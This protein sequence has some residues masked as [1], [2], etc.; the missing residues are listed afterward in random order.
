M[1]L[2][3]IDISTRNWRDIRSQLNNY[4]YYIIK[5][6]NHAKEITMY[7]SKIRPAGH[8]INK[9]DMFDENDP[10]NWECSVGTYSVNFASKPRK[11]YKID[12]YFIEIYEIDDDDF[13][14][15]EVKKYLGVRNDY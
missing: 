7:C 5:E 12:D 4:S 2:K 9:E 8:V 13:I 11:D 3:K 1:K 14:K 10:H 6:Y 15:Q